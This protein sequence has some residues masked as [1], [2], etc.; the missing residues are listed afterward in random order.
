MKKN[1]KKTVWTD[2]RKCVQTS[3]KKHYW[4]TFYSLFVFH[5]NMSLNSSAC[6][7]LHTAYVTPFSR[8]NYALIWHR[9]SRCRVVYQQ[10]KWVKFM[11]QMK[12]EKELIFVNLRRR[13]PLRAT[14][15]RPISIAICCWWAL[16]PSLPVYIKK[17]T[18]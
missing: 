13:G 6:M 3:H 12:K 4:C 9:I 5:F 2:R 14:R 16:R 11:R 7:Y 10:T 15:A 1:N 18:K 17:Q 8:A